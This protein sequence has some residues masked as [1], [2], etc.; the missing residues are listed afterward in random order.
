MSKK[1]TDDSGKSRSR[2]ASATTVVKKK[3]AEKSS[4]PATS[5]VSGLRPALEK[6]EGLAQGQPPEGEDDKTEHPPGLSRGGVV[7]SDCVDPTE[8]DQADLMSPTGLV[9]SSLIDRGP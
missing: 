5:R 6:A 2:S 1:S 7:Y 8:M 4:S 3:S 9:V